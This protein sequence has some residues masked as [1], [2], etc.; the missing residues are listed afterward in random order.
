MEPSTFGA[1]ALHFYR[2]LTPPART[3]AG[4]SILNPYK[5]VS[6]QGYLESFFKKFY[7]DPASR[8]LVFGINPGRFGSGVT[9]ISFT[10]P[11]ALATFCGIPNDLPK[12]RELSS[13]F[14]YQFIDTWGGTKS[15]YRQ[16]FLTA[17]VPLG[18]TKGNVNYNYYDDPLLYKRVKPFMIKNIQEQ[19][20]IAGNNRSAI[21]LGTGKNKKIFDEINAE[22]CFFKN[23]YTVE[24]PRFIMQYRR[25]HITDY[26]KKYH[27]VFTAALAQ[28]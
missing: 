24:H 21:I 3:V 27:D 4:I 17:L 6:V 9:G 13:D 18:F 8:V 1:R 22:Y 12:K 26:L 10:D 25:N 19:I 16:F 11:V 2:N 20:A 5:E 14:I 23:V 28:K 15:F 7:N